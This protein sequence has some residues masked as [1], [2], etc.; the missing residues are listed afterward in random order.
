MS[1][2]DQNEVGLEVEGGQ[3]A[4]E[5]QEKGEDETGVDERGVDDDGE[6]DEAVA[7]HL[8]PPRWRRGAR[9]DAACRSMASAYT[10]SVL[11]T[12]RGTVNSRRARACAWRPSRARSSSSSSRRAERRRE[13]GRVTRRHREPG[14][15]VGIGVGDTGGKVGGHHRRARG[16]RLDLHEAEGLAAG[17]ARQA[18]HVGGTVPGAELIVILGGEEGHAGGDAARGGELAQLRSRAARGRSARGRRPRRP[19]RAR[20]RRR[21]CSTRAGRR[22]ARSCARRGRRAA[23]RRARRTAGVAARRWAGRPKGTTRHFS[24][25]GA[26][27]AELLT[28]FGDDVTMRSTLSRNRSRKGRYAASRRFWRTMSLW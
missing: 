28:M 23:P 18:E 3:P 8:R 22:R 5:A 21:P 10:S 15:P 19:W 2:G 26:R 17:H 4:F 7:R 6:G 20:E 12:M 14:D 1:T 27:N 9:C 25:R 13:R 24:A 16:V 11:A